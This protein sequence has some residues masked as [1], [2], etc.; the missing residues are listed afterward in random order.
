MTTVPLTYCTGATDPQPDSA[1]NCSLSE[2]SNL[3]GCPMWVASPDWTSCQVRPNQDENCIHNNVSVYQGLRTRPVAC[4]QDTT[5]ETISISACSGVIGGDPTSIP[6]SEEKCVVKATAVSVRVC[7][8][9][10][11]AWRVGNWSM[12]VV[13]GGGRLKCGGKG[14]KTRTVECIRTWGITEIHSVIVSDELCFSGGGGL[15]R[16]PRRGR[17]NNGGGGGGGVGRRP[18]NSRECSRACKTG[19]REGRVVGP[20]PPPFKWVTAEWSNVSKTA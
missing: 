17:R 7:T 18:K 16:R 19:S 13:D 3:P 11:Y 14:K 4:V 12:C 15:A 8:G 6:E 1:T 2:L 10:T 20:R 5:N 9:V